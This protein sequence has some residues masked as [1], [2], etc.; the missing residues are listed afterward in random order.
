MVITETK[1]KQTKRKTMFYF[2]EIVL[3]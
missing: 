2:S 3:F 1:L